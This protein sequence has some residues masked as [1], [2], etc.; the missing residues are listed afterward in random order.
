[1]RLPPVLPALVALGLVLPLAGCSAAEEVATRAGG[2][3]SSAAVDVAEREARQV[4]CPLV[5]DRQVSEQ[6]RERIAAAVDVARAAGVD[7]PLVDDAEDL[8]GTDGTPPE[9]A[10]ARLA[11][12]CAATP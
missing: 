9:S 5:E 6:D 3:A 8:L 1:M 7:S 2:E 4:L 11:D 10:V 12:D